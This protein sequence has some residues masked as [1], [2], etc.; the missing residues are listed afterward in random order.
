M[1]D[2]RVT[3][4]NLALTNATAVAFSGP[5]TLAPA[6]PPLTFLFDLALTPSKPVNMPEHYAHRTVQVGY[7][8]PYLPPVEVKAM[9]ATIGA[10]SLT[11]LGFCYLRSKP[12]LP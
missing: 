4:T 6:D 5:R 9:G 10:S 12:S 1:G 3:F 7:G 2:Y 11:D 8:T